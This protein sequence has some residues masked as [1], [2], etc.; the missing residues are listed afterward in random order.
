MQVL[1]IT[2]QTGNNIDI[3]K[4]QDF[5]LTSFIERRSKDKDDA[6][7]IGKRIRQVLNTKTNNSIEVFIELEV[8]NESITFV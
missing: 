8:A 4:N 1:R 2:D 3:M 6:E 5:I 7:L